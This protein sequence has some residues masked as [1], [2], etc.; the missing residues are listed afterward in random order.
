MKGLKRLFSEQN[1]IVGVENDR[2]SESKKIRDSNSGKEFF[3]PGHVEDYMVS[4]SK[5]ITE[6]N[7]ARFCDSDWNMRKH[8][9]KVKKKV[10]RL[11][12]AVQVHSK[13]ISTIED[14]T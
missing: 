12:P 11:I 10:D 6:F 2:N 1:N 8:L 3:V 13:R 5:T 7:N 9:T 14:K 4:D